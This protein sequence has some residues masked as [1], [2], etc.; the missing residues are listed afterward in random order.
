VA[1]LFLEP[2][3]LIV[4]TKG[5]DSDSKIDFISKKT[6]VFSYMKIII[7]INKGSASAAEILAGALKDNKKAVL[8][9]TATFGKGSVQTVIPLQ[10]GAGL[11]L[12][13]AAY[14][15]PSGKNLMDKGI[16]PDVTVKKHKVVRKKT[17]ENKSLGD[18]IFRKVEKLT[19]PEDVSFEE[20]TDAEKNS[21]IYD[22]QLQAAI[23]ILKGAEIFCANKTERENRVRSSYTTQQVR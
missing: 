1:D 4:Y 16:E 3:K 20:E 23:D 17:S 19:S 18:E 5:R 13:T 9:G 22:N 6:P 8:V 2:G 10:D 15:T 12:T 14:F 7:L 21:V 11:R